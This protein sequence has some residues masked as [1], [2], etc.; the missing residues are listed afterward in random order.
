MTVHSAADRGGDKRERILAAAERV[1]ARRGF[2]AARVSE[3]AKDAGVADGT[4]YLYFKSKDDLLISLFEMRMKQVND[5]LRTAIDGAE[6]PLDQL[7]AFIRAYLQLVHDEPAAAEVLTIE[8]R[9]SS[10]FMKEYDNPQFADFLRMLGGILT[11]GAERGDLDATI[12]AHV[13][14]RMIFGMLDEIAL[15]WVLAKQPAISAA[16][17][18]T[19]P[20]KFDIVRAAD[21]VVALV[22]RGLDRSKE[23]SQ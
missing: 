9:Q 16:T 7:R 8:L 13:A 2:F 12:P 22:M 17:P 23:K 6:R 10:K 14:A 3:I 11:A 1:F 21:W 20:K 4:I 15:A 18:G 19:R 5:V